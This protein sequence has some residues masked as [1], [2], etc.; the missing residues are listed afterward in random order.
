M[1]REIDLSD[2]F[3]QEMLAGVAERPPIE[4]RAFYNS[5]GDCIEFLFA[6]E[7]YYAERVDDLLTVYYGQASREIVGGLIK[8]A[9]RF[10]QQYVR[11]Q[12]GF[13]I[14][15]E[16]GSTRLAG[17]FTAGMWQQADAARGRT[18]KR[19]R[20]TAEEFDVTVEMPALA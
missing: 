19:L 4:P 18:Y 6:D 12:P 8:G 11:E 14:E 3:A 7:S 16:D 15:I 20:D 9:Q 1:I 10:L 17:I 5:D 2:E 13:V